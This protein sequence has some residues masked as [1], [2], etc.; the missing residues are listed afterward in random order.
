[1]FRDFVYNFAVKTIQYSTNKLTHR[2]LSVGLA[3]FLVIRLRAQ[4]INYSIANLCQDVNKQ[5]FFHLAGALLEQVFS[6]STS[7]KEMFR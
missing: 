1:M 7:F 2:P 4:L 3:D 6:M 5:I